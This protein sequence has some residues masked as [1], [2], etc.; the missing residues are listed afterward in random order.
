MMENSLNLLRKT[1]RIHK[2]Q[3]M[4]L[5][6]G[7]NLTISEWELLNNVTVDQNTQEILSGIMDLD[8]ST[9]SRQLKN[10]VT[11]EMLVKEATG[12][13]HRQ[14]IYTITKKGEDAKAQIEANVKD[15]NTLIFEHWSDEE[16]QLLQIL[17]NRLVKSVDR[18]DD[19]LEKSFK[20]KN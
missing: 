6:K 20:L 4:Q 18:I 2:Q 19:S 15:L 3:L 7:E 17:L 9:L 13:D 14:L 1:A 16:Q 10:L 11:K 8:T 5:T 12:K